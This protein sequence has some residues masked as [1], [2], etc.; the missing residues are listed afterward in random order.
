[1][2]RARAG[3]IEIVEEADTQRLRNRQERAKGFEPSTQPHNFK[4]NNTI[5]VTGGVKA[6]PSPLVPMPA[7][8]DF[9]A[10]ASAWPRL[11]MAIKAGIK[12]MIK[13]AS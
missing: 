7:D 9:L 5:L 13:A 12:A 6:S 1:M 2:V 10:L 4:E 8:E 11:P 3:L